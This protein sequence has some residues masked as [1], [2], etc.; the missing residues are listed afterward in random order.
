MPHFEV[1]LPNNLKV[2]VEAKDRTE[3]ANKAERTF[4]GSRIRSL[5]TFLPMINS[6]APAEIVDN[7]PVGMGSQAD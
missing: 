2:R 4:G 1:E 7:I 5:A 6:K 3:A